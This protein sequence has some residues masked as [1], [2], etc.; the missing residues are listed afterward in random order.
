MVHIGNLIRK[1]LREK[2]I[3]VVEFAAMADVNSR[4]MYRILRR[5]SID[6][7][8]LNRYAHLLDHDFFRDLSDAIHLE[9][10][11]R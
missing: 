6:S 7:A 1:V 8:E 2:K 3:S 11:G 4:T 5:E 10:E 9:Q